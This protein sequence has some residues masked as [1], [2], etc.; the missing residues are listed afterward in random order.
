MTK[1]TSNPQSLEFV[2]K[3]ILKNHK[4]RQYE[5]AKKINICPVIF[6]KQIRNHL[7]I[8]INFIKRIKEQ[9]PNLTQKEIQLLE[10]F[11]NNE[12]KYNLHK[13]HQRKKDKHHEPHNID[14][15]ICEIQITHSLHRYQLAEKLQM[16]PYELSNVAKGTRLPKNFIERLQEAS[17]ITEEQ[18]ERLKNAIYYHSRRQRKSILKAHKIEIKT[19]LQ[20]IFKQI[21][22]LK[23]INTQPIIDKI[24][25][26]NNIH[27]S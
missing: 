26:L 21:E 7:P 4:L 23:P 20:D 9:M 14:S 3:A 22:D 24:Q 6:N 15:I 10:P 25:S 2:I 5:L 18:T 13:I 12:A 1:K 17:L 11:E 19:M 8:P 16:I 27:N